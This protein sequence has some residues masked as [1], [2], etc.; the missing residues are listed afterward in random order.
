MLHA[1]YSLYTRRES[2]SE[3]GTLIGAGAMPNFSELGQGE[4]LRIN[5]LSI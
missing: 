1:R 5:F 4:V 2:R 3:F